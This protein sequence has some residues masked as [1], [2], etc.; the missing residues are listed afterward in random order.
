MVCSVGKSN[1]ISENTRLA[2]KYGSI[3]NP[4]PGLGLYG[5]RT[6]AERMFFFTI[7]YGNIRNFIAF[8]DIRCIL[9]IATINS[10]FFRM[11]V[12]IFIGYHYKA[13]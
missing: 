5:L 2:S 6:D 7:T 3:G 10:I 1:T 12:L 13:Y 4:F 11:K 8:F 9:I